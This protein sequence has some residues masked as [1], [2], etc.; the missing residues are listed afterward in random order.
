MKVWNAAMKKTRP[1]FFDGRGMNDWFWRRREYYKGTYD[2]NDWAI[3]NGGRRVPGINA[4]AKASQSK[5]NRRRRKRGD[6]PCDDNR[7]I[8]GY[9]EAD[10]I[11]LK[12]AMSRNP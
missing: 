6:R 11:L 10:E 12:A 7:N 9:K 2:Y 1:I 5:P 8:A 4:V 3:D